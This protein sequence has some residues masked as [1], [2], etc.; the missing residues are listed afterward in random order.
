VGTNA[1][2]YLQLYQQ[3]SRHPFVDGVAMHAVIQALLV[4]V[5]SLT[6]KLV[7][8][9]GNLCNDQSLQWYNDESRCISTQI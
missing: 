9:E 6:G 7:F 5:Q 2:A 8:A 3:S 4:R 1:L